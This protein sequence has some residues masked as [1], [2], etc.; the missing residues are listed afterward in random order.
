MYYFDNRFLSQ[1]VDQK[2]KLKV[3]VDSS[4]YDIATKKDLADPIDGIGYDVYGKDHRFDYRDIEKIKA[5][6]NVINI[7]TLQK[8][9]VEP[10]PVKLDKKS[11][12]GKSDSGGGDEEMPEEEP[13]P[14][15]PEE[16][17]EEPASGGK[18]PELSHYDPYMIGRRMIKELRR[19]SK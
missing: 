11:P 5:G 13:M 12:G 16:E 19:K 17:E 3:F 10:E 15:E 18:K 7:D 14:E 1:Y 8:M 4:W 9:M 2:V 6:Q